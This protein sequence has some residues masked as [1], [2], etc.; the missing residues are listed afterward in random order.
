MGSCLEK[1]IINNG[2]NTIRV[3]V[4][5]GKNDLMHVGKH[6]RTRCK[7]SCKVT[8]DQDDEQKNK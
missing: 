2:I 8:D 3:V 7:V 5:Y 4:I 6:D 1:L